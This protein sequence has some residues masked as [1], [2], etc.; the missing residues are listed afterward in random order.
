MPQAV[1]AA[2]AAWW[3]STAVTVA[4]YAVT[5]GA[6]VKAAILVASVAYSQA[7]TSKMRRAMNASSLDQGRTVMARDPIAARRLIYG[8]VMVSGPIVFIHTTGAKNEYLYLIIILA[9]HEV[10]EIG[11][12]Y[13]N[14]ELV[15][16][17]GVDNAATGKYAGVARCL[18][19]RGVPGDTADHYLVAET[20]AFW[21]S[22]HKLSGC[23][24]LSVRLKWSPDLFPNGLPN[25]RAVVKGKKVYDP[26]TATTVYSNNSALCAADYLTDTTF[27]K[28]VAQARVREADLIEAANIC[29]EDV[30][31]ADASTEKRYTTNGTI[32]ADQ[33]PGEILRDLAG[34]MA[35]RIV[36]TGGTWTIRAGAYRAPGLTL[37]D[38][39]LMGA[40]SVQPRQSRQDTF[41]R[42]RGLYISPENQWA[43]A[44]FPAVPNSTYKAADGGIWL[45]RDVQ[46]NFTTSPATAQRL[47]K[48]ELE[49]G[50]QQITVSAQYTLKA[51]QCMPGDT[52]AITRERLGWSAKEFEVVEWS[53]VPVGQGES[54]GLG[55]EMTLRE[56]AAGVWDWNDGEETTVDLAPNTTLPNPFSVPTPSITTLSDTTTVIVQPDGTV[57]PRIKVSW[58]TPDNIHVEAGGFV[59]IEYKRT[60]DSTW[61]PW[62]AARGDTLEDYI[63]ADLRVGVSYDVRVRFRNNTGVRGSYDTDTGIAVVGDTTNPNAPASISATPMPG[64]IRV[65]WPPSTSNTVNEYAIE[66]ST[67]SAVSGFSALAETPNSQYDDGGVTPGTTYWYRVTARSRSELSSTTVTSGGVIALNPAVGAVVPNNPTAATD[68]GG[69]SAGTYGAGDGT[70]FAFRTIR[71]PALPANAVWQNLLYRRNG[72]SEW[73]VAAQLKNAGNADVRIDDLTPGVSYDVATQAWSAAGGSNIIA[74]TSSPFTAPNKG[75]GP[76]APSSVTYKSGSDSNYGRPPV[77]QGGALMPSILVTW[78]APSDSDLVGFEWSVQGSNVA[79][80]GSG[81]FITETEIVIF[82]P[83]FSTSYFFIRAKNRSGQ[84][85]S[86]AGGGTNLNL[87]YGYP[88][89]DMSE[90][91][92]NDVEVTGIKVGSGSVNDVLV[93]QP[94]IAGISIG[95]GVPET[96][97]N[98]SLS[99]MGF[100]TAPDSAWFQ[101]ANPVIQIRYDWD[102]SSSSNAVLRIKTTDGSNLPSFLIINGE[103]V[104]YF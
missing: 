50:R 1:P 23:A 17:D 72:A 101:G 8:E 30:V 80:A 89:G 7:Q 16:F 92:A 88:A 68:L 73:L 35:G 33:Q 52:L 27:G 49:R 96:S 18:K 15:P 31:L 6:I 98:L 44:D 28:G 74:A 13:F 22:A 87:T 85:S 67:T 99:G 9:G 37:T 14:D 55:I 81:S 97:Y 86:W 64:F 32:N 57:M 10:E 102:D 83:T 43:P 62:N 36:D 70:V 4:G 76:N 69:G 5:Y 66:R 56:T 19:K 29:D 71:V 78:T 34:A 2:V 26:R 91:D 79:P 93:R 40:I 104:E 53:L 95:G 63:A 82:S 75:S 3:G 25:I 84:F 46:Y 61:L 11:D 65:A 38:G 90:Q 47:A 41:N 58:A 20:P 42:M 39:D 12:V 48:I 103:L 54:M 51:L 100:G 94:Y 77:Y 60:A 59:E 24:Y 21:T 45:D